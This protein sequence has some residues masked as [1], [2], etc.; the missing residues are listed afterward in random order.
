[1]SRAQT[2]TL[3]ILGA[4]LGVDDEVVE[5]DGRLLVG[6]LPCPSS[7]GG[8]EAVTGVLRPEAAFICTRA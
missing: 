5:T 3:P 7:L 8:E 6:T 4:G 1:M 2:P